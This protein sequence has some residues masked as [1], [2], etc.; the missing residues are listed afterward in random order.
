M[1][2]A[3]LTWK[4][5]GVLKD[6][7]VVVPL[8]SLEQ[9]GFHLP[10][11]TDTTIVTAIADRV[12]QTVPEVV[13][14]PTVWTGH[15]PHHRRF[16]AVS[17]DVR[18]YM[19]LVASLCRSLVQMGARKIVLL[20]GHGGNDVPTKAAMREI[21]SEFHDMPDLYVV[22]A[23]YWALAAARFAEIRRSAV[24][25]MGHACE[26]ETA[27]MLALDP[28]AVRVDRAVEGG[29]RDAGPWRRLDMLQG[30][31][32]YIVNEF[33]ELSESGTIGQPHYASV[34]QGEQFLAAAVEAVAALVREV[35]TWTYQ[36]RG[37][38]T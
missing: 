29:P 28:D 13:V 23:T 19:D 17:L 1:Q 37:L 15:S 6:A 30:Q 8:G 4:D 21:K 18:P 7:V 12:E 11:F 3:K 36:E 33:D 2:L 5:L 14:T 27:V 22:Y 9:H 31:P 10:L 32:Y 20:N 35:G 38:A 16:G 34:E 25:G 24:G 26:M